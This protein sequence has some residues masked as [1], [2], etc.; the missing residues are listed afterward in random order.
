MLS[1]ITEYGIQH[2]RVLIH[3]LRSQKEDETDFPLDWLQLWD[4]GSRW[5]SES[6]EDFF[7]MNSKKKMIENNII[8]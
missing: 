5:I 4:T 7:S 6:N 3:Y 2:A 1:V 8:K